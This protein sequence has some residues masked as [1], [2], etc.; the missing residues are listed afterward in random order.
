MLLKL[1]SCN[2]YCLLLLSVGTVTVN[3]TCKRGRETEDSVAYLHEDVA[4]R[5][6]RE[7]D[8]EEDEEAALEVVGSHLRTEIEGSKHTRSNSSKRFTCAQ[9]CNS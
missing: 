6:E 5:N 2:S 8:E 9:Y 7:E 4:G 1:L 3:S